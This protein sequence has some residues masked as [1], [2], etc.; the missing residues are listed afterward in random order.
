[1]IEPER[2]RVNSRVPGHLKFVKPAASTI[3]IFT[4][5]GRALSSENSRV[6]L[7]PALRFSLGVA[8]KFFGTRRALSVGSGA[9]V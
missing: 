7:S 8:S 2:G 9:G 1:M 5:T 3:S 6:S 4:F